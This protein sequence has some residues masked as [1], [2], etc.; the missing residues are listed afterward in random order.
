MARESNMEM[1][2]YEFDLGLSNGAKMRILQFGLNEHRLIFK[3]NLSL[4][5]KKELG[6]LPD[7]VGEIGLVVNYRDGISQ[8]ICLDMNFTRPKNLG[9]KI[10]YG[11]DF[12]PGA[13]LYLEFP[14]TK[15]GRNYLLGK[16][17]CPQEEEG[18]R[19]KDTSL[20]KQEKIP[21]TIKEKIELEFGKYKVPFPKGERLE[22]FF[23]FPES[24]RKF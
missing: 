18:R 17:Y 13:K 24:I 11:L 10:A 15:A 22:D 4:P 14:Y 23:E 12:S 5:E 2:N 3:Y 19:F 1:V 21:F 20:I 8:E 16:M 7:L 6:E 9:K